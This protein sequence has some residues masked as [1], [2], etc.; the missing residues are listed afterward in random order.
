MYKQIDGVTMGSPLGPALAN[1]FVGYLEKKIPRSKFP[2]LYHRFV[3][4]T[5]AIFEDNSG[6]LSFFEDLNQ[7]H[8]SLQFTMESENKNKLLFMDVELKKTSES[9]G[10]YRPVNVGFTVYCSAQVLTRLLKFNVHK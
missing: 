2:L 1:I 7:L 9:H 8:P 3:D 5:F 4:D 6:V 10:I